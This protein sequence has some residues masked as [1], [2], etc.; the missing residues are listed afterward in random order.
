MNMLSGIYA[1]DSGSI[2][3][4]GQAGR[5]FLPQDA[6]RLGIGMVHQHFKL[7]DVLSAA[8]NIWMGRKRPG[9]CCAGIGMRRSLR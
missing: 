5:H 6:K 4:G 2:R 7:V 9:R 8:D 1:P 3:V